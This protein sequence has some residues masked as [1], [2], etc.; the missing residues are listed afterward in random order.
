MKS[1]TRVFRNKHHNGAMIR[2]MVHGDGLESPLVY[3]T[4]IYNLSYILLILFILRWIL[5]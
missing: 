1:L 3:K 5:S 4:V 2:V